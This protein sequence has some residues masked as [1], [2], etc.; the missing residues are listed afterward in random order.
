MMG[1]TSTV[2][3]TNSVN[4]AVLGDFRKPFFKDWDPRFITILILSLV[5]ETTLVVYLASRP[6]PEYS[7][8]DIA[9]VQERFANFILGEAVPRR[10]EGVV[11]SGVSE[12][13]T[14]ED[15]GAAET[16]V[17]ESTEAGGE[18][19]GTSAGEGGG[20]TEASASRA[21]A[22]ESRR[23][24]REAMARDVSNRGLLGLLTGTGQAAE[25][26]AVSSIFDAQ[27]SGSGVGDDLDRVLSSVNGLKT[28]EGSGTG[29]GSGGEFGARGG[30]SGGRAG[31]DDLV[32]EREGARSRSLSR[33][34]ELTI[35]APEA[36]EG[37]GRRSI[38]RSP[39]AIQE[40]LLSH[41][42]A[43]RYC[44]ERELKRNPN[45]KG[46]ITVRITVSPDGSVK[47]AVIVSS[48]MN[49]ERVE[50]CILARIRLWKDFPP[51]DPSEGDVSFR[52]VYTFG[53]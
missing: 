42:S 33:K 52:Q 6:A 51:I 10:Q 26:R 46:K 45:L 24:A 16:G 34:G 27:G 38:H 11:P 44:Y 35:E 40:V 36:V 17:D 47:D 18:G 5:F 32:T 30:R 23:V 2:K 3:I 8:R 7:E 43:V 13:G 37:L 4:P 39:D 14:V 19:A 50:R 9:R 29:T 41:V 31:I 53:T 25:G 28:G 1:N 48:T 12:A 22:A 21:S 49:S 15:E 20:A